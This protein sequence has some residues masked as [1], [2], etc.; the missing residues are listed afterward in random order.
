MR[1]KR[2]LVATRTPKAAT[3]RNTTMLQSQIAIYCMIN[4]SGRSGQI[5]NS[6]RGKLLLA[7]GFHVGFRLPCG[8]VS[9]ARPSDSGYVLQHMAGVVVAILAALVQEVRRSG[10]IICFVALCVSSVGEYSEPH[11]SIP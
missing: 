3:Q 5:A 8:L 4:L 1:Q 6:T 9:A 2:S 7:S 10:E 11:T